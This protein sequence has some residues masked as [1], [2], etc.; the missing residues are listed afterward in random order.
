MKEI[1]KKKELGIYYTPS[2]LSDVLCELTINETDT[3]ILEPSFGGCA[4]LESIFN[5]LKALGASDPH[6]NIFGCD[7]DESAFQHLEDWGVNGTINHYLKRDFLKTK[8]ESF[9]GEKFDLIIGNPPYV[10][11]HNMDEKQKKTLNDYWSKNS[12]PFT[13]K[14]S[15]WAYFLTHSTRLLKDGGKICFILPSIAYQNDYGKE[16]FNK[17]K[18]NFKKID[19]YLLE[20]EFFGHENTEEKIGVL[21]AEGYSE[22]K[23]SP[24]SKI[25]YF[26]ASKEDFYSYCQDRSISHLKTD[27]RNDKSSIYALYEEDSF[28]ELGKLLDIK[29]GAVSGD[30]KFFILSENQIKDLGLNK[31]HF[32]KVIRRF[33]DLDG[34]ELK[35]SDF[36]K[37]NEAGKRVWM[38]SPKENDLGEESL[39]KY[40]DS[41]DEDKIKTNKTFQKNSDWWKF[42]QG[43]IPDAFFS[44]M[45]KWGASLILNTAKANCTNSVHKAFFKSKLSKKDKLLISI[46]L[47][48]SY[49]QL[50][51]ELE[52]RIYSSNV[53]KFEPTLSKEI[54][55][56][57]IFNIGHNI[58][59]KEL[60]KWITK[61]E[62]KTYLEICYEADKLLQKIGFKNNIGT[63][64]KVRK[65]KTR[66]MKQRG[67]I[68]S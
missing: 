26:S 6:K 14:A 54:R 60:R 46:A 27:F 28:I 65:L 67:V 18:S 5:R 11:I 59:F 16:V 42:P 4:F 23:I 3:R 31:E 51:S 7:I 64:S 56:P 24:K 62:N 45:N 41:Y 68:S 35:N 66:L 50:S 2:G 17:L 61:N 38:F 10:S 22:D 1:S 9:G 30:N 39:V 43:A 25:N 12:L 15:S 32:K 63:Y 55:L 40:L 8:L 48:S 33:G 34:F 29:I 44:Y 58:T 49:A 52:S 53:L 21:I 37:L 36:R 19:W 57:N 20:D 47:Q 13:K